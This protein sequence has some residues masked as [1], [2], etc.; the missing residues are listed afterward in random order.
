MC[1]HWLQKFFSIILFLVISI[2]LSACAKKSTYV[3]DADGE[4]YEEEVVSDP[5]EPMNRKLFSLHKWLDKAFFRPLAVSYRAVLP[6]VARK[7]VGN[8]FTNVDH[9]PI[10]INNILQLRPMDAGNSAARLV[11]NTT[12]GIGGL[13]DVATPLGFEYHK[14]D[15]GQTFARWGWSNSTFV[16][17]PLFGPTTFR[18]GVGVVGD[19]YMTPWP[20]LHDAAEWSSAAV[21]AVDKRSQFM[22]TEPILTVAAL[23]EYSFIRDGYLISRRAFITGLADGEKGEEGNFGDIL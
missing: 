12:A 23:D 9:I 4:F 1:A 17:V 13:F 10:T 7:S 8:F 14:S 18:D 11:I 15:L 16:F 20:Y 22:E 19:L 5:L 2:G 6:P 21:Y 3:E